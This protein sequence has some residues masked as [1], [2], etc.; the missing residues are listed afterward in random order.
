MLDVIQLTFDLGSLDAQTIRYAGLIQQLKHAQEPWPAQF[1][2]LPRCVSKGLP[3]RWLRLL[4][5]G[6]SDLSVRS[7][8]GRTGPK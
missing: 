6:A 4:L 3:S 8:W 1:L 7:R 2:I 5:A